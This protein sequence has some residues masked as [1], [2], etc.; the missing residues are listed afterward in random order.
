M[1]WV[2][3]EDFKPVLIDR[4]FFLCNNIRCQDVEGLRLSWSHH[5]N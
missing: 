4:L 1:T 2:V 3:L 5:V